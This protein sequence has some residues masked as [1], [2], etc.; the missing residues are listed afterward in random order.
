MNK[1]EKKLFFSKK[2]LS[3]NKNFNSRL[4]PW[5]GEKDPYKIWLSEIILQQTRVEQGKEYYNH[6]IKKY[7]NIHLLANAREEEVFKLWEGL[8]YYSRCKN[9][10]STAKLISKEW[11]GKFPNKYQDILKLRGVGPYT[12]AAIASFA[13]DLPH[14]VVDGNVSRI[15]SRVF[16]IQTPIDSPKGKKIIYDLAD[17]LLSKN[18]SSVYNQAIMD[19]GATVCKPQL[20]LCSQCP[21]KA[22]CSAFSANMVKILPKKEKVIVKKQRWFY[23]FIAE[24]K[25]RVF[26]KKRLKKDIWQNLHEFIL[27]E[28]SKMFT[29][30]QV[31]KSEGLKLIPEERPVIIK[32]SGLCKQQLTHQTINGYFIHIKVKNNAGLEDYQAID[33][34][35]IQN[36]AF[37]KFITEYCLQN[38]PFNVPEA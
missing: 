12:A 9:L 6:F 24:N 4:M 32:I 30:M 27:I 19:F 5:K 8:G 16:G 31:I 28:K 3:W 18:H 37:P 26:I 34:A 13:F 7:P 36:L 1:A 11:E 21:L 35:D 10:H 38:A 25:G 22:V 17:E 33:K 14:A 20:P 29:P 15:L 2:L 23:Y